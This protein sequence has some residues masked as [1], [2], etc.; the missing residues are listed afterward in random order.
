[1][2]TV[3]LIEEEQPWFASGAVYLMKMGWDEAALRERLKMAGARWLPDRKL[4]KPQEPSPAASDSRS[5][6]S[7]GRSSIRYL[8]VDV[9]IY[10]YR[11]A[12]TGSC[13]RLR[14]K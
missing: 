3:E 6:S 8:Q 4:C 1:M 9:D 14:L 5:G 10:S 13:G 12:S 7:P 2:K 11:F